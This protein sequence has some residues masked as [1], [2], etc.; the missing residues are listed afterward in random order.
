MKV[1]NRACIRNLSLKGLRAARTRNLIAVLAIAL[2]TVMFTSLFTIAA[3]INHSFQQ[4]NFRMAGG[5]MHASIKN[6]TWEQAEQLRAEGEEDIY[7][8]TCFSD[9]DK[10]LSQ[11]QRQQ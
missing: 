2:T 6:I 7:V 1:S 9:R 4:E 3:S 8:V 5:D 11:T 10:F